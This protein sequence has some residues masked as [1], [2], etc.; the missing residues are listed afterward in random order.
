MENQNFE[1]SE[2]VL[3]KRVDKTLQW[4]EKS[5]DTWKEKAIETKASL[6]KQKL[7]VKRARGGRDLF[8]KGLLEKTNKLENT[9]KELK[10][11]E[12]EIAKLKAE[13][14]KTNKEVVEVKKKRLHH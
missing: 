5:R 10:E 4:L 2:G 13:L 11:K 12:L 7:A 1:C 6:K 3:P 14:E 8:K 9:Q